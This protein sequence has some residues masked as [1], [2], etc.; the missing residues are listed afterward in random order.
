LGINCSIYFEDGTSSQLTN[1]NDFYVVSSV[2]ENT[3]SDRLPSKVIKL[4]LPKDGKVGYINSSE[5]TESKI[6][7]N[8]T[9]ISS[10]ANSLNT[11]FSKLIINTRLE[12][13]KNYEAYRMNE[14]SKVQ[15]HNDSIRLI[16]NINFLKTRKLNDSIRQINN[17]I[18]SL[19]LLNSKTIKQKN[20]FFYL[21][22]SYFCDGNANIDLIL[23]VNGKNNKYELIGIKSKDSKFYY[24]D[25]LIWNEDFI[26]NFKNSSKCLIRVNQDY[27]T[28]DYFEF[29]MN[30][31][32]SAYNFVVK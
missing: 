9:Q 25:E 7:Q 19:N 20:P 11:D 24:F 30:G 14:L 22:G 16:D 15:S 10:N 28:D 5:L 12:S 13:S 6:F 26:Q 29:N 1:N 18:D 32:A 4:W 8:K 23:I 2:L 31:S 21:S 3:V 17:Y 27:C